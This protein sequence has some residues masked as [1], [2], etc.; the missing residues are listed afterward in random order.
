[1][2]IEQAKT[3]ETRDRRLASALTVLRAPA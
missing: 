2:P 1:L 3:D